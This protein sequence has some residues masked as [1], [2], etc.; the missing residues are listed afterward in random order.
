MAG[1]FAIREADEQMARLVG[2][3]TGFGSAGTAA[4]PEVR[5]GRVPSAGSSRPSRPGFGSAAT[6][7]GAGYAVE[8]PSAPLS[9]ADHFSSTW[10][11]FQIASATAQ[12]VTNIP[13]ITNPAALMLKLAMKF[14]NEP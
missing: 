14:Q 6:G 12:V 11:Y 4:L 9:L 8:T 10:A 2:I 1:S 13:T 5:S 3:A 7:H